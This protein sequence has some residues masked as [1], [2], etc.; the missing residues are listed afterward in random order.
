MLLKKRLIFHK[1]DY[2]YTEL[3]NLFDIEE[4]VKKN[5]VNQIK[6]LSFILRQTLNI[7]DNKEHLSIK[8]N[9]R[10]YINP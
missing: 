1:G 10:V 4:P 3:K 5:G 8:Q 6:F 2:S 7:L 9:I